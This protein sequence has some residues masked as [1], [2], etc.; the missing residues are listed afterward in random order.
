[1]K[2]S[3]KPIHI[4]DEREHTRDITGFNKWTRSSR[5]ISFIM[6]LL[7]W[8]TIPAEV[9]LRKDFGQRWFTVL[10]FYAGLLLLLIFSVVQYLIHWVWD[11]C[12][13]FITG[14]ITYFNSTYEPPE[15]TLTDS[16]MNKSMRFFLVLYLVMG[17]YH[18]FK[19]WWRN[20]T[21][22]A[23][24]SFDDGTSRLMPV[25]KYI[26]EPL[27]AIAVPITA[28]AMKLLPKQ[29]RT[30]KTVPK[31]ITNPA[32]F[33]NTVLEPVLLFL[34]AH[35]LH[36]M[37]SLWL[38]VSAIAIAL[39]AQW[40]ENTRL[41]KI[42]DFRDSIIE[43]KVMMELKEGILEPNAQGRIM[44]QAA[45]TIKENPQLVTQVNPQYSSLMSIINDMNQDRSHLAN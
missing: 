4:E 28:L 21:Q 33:T 27:N 43:A 3:P 37:V 32:S 11:R 16:I 9:L 42:L 7:G 18:L 41:N 26:I 40:R 13:N 34:L 23:L 29:Q 10:N 1:M 20:R 36:G 5:T 15:P 12:Q 19:I 2:L 39:Y 44:Q 31:L 35:W 17:A 25:A 22:T 24:H 38:Y 14:I 45:A 8:F 6:A 30:V